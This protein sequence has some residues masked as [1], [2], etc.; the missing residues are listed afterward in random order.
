MELE[1]RLG[2][3]AKEIDVLRLILLGMGEF[4][5]QAI[6]RVQEVEEGVLKSDIPLLLVTTAEAEVTHTPPHKEL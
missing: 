3:V 6:V 2:V 1:E 4:I 5:T